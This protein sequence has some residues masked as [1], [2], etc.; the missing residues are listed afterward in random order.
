MQRVLFQ[1]VEVTQV[2]SQASRVLPGHGTGIGE[3]AI[4]DDVYHDERSLLRLVFSVLGNVIVGTLLLS[5]MFIL[6]HIVAA[7]LS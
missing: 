1:Q 4:N 7:I 5:A 3:Q 6:P 2:R